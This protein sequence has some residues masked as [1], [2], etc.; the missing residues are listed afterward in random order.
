MPV[1]FDQGSFQVEQIHSVSDFMG[2][3]TKVQHFASNIL[4][5]NKLKDDIVFLAPVAETLKKIIKCIA[6]RQETG[7]ALTLNA[8]SNCIVNNECYR[9]VLR[10]AFCIFFEF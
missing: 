2:P 1:E 8:C 7:A 3:F 10:K 6:I 5:I 4:H 9:L